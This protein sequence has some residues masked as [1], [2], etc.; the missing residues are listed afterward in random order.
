[1][2]YLRCCLYELPGLQKVAEQRLLIGADFLDHGVL[3]FAQFAGVLVVGFQCVY[4]PVVGEHHAPDPCRECSQSG[5]NPDGPVMENRGVKLHAAPVLFHRQYVTI[6]DRP[7]SRPMQGHAV[8]FERVYGKGSRA[9]LMWSHTRAGSRFRR[10]LNWSQVYK[11]GVA[12]SQHV[13]GDLKQVVM[14]ICYLDPAFATSLIVSVLLN[15]CVNLSEPS[16]AS[17]QALDTLANSSRGQNHQEESNL[18]APGDYL[19]V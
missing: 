16:S 11:T 10:K 2:A 15:L 3:A 6:V 4:A 9:R 1:M 19:T 7:R 17:R 8:L 14:Q 13:K 5:C 12:I 18:L